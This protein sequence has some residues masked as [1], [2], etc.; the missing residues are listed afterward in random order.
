MANPNPYTVL[1]VAVL[2]STDE[3]KAAYKQLAAKHHPDKHANDPKAGA[4]MREIN[5]AWEQLKTPELRQATNK[6]LIT[7]ALQSIKAEKPVTRH[8]ARTPES[9]VPPPR[10]VPPH[11]PPIRPVQPEHSNTGVDW[12]SIGGI[13]L[14]IAIILGGIALGASRK[15]NPYDPS[16]DRYRGPDGRFTRR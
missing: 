14:G 1:G 10:N 5:H 15:G 7:E 13:G 8:P 16:V 9:G 11:T 12:R 6:S 2:A 3:L 4:R